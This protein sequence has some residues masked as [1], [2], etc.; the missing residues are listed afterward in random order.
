MVLKKKDHLSSRTG[1]ADRGVGSGKK[2]N[3]DV[4]YCLIGLL[5][6]RMSPWCADSKDDEDGVN[7]PK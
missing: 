2:I 6:E 3:G 1:F 7:R 5:I 4:S